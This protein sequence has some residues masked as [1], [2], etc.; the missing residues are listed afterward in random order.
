[1]VTTSDIRNGVTF[2]YEGSIFVVIEFMH[3]LQNKTAFVRTKVK[4]LRTGSTTDLKFLPGEKF[5]KAI[6]DKTEMQYI[7]SSGDMLVFMNTETYE[8]SEVPAAN[9][10]NEAKFL[11][12][13]MNVKIISYK[14]E[15]LGLELPDKVV[16]EVT[17]A[18]PAV[19]GD[20][21]TNALKDAIVQTGLLVKV[22]MFIEEGERI[23]VSTATGEYVSREK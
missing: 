13:G 9:C 8:Q 4:N 12:E 18:A 2:E 15:M 7:Y 1:M 10:A 20:T 5:P 3:V 6:I 11:V 23:I 14:D 16:L 17:E 19:K 21:K 22:P